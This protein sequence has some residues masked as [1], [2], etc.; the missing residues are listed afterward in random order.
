MA[1]RRKGPRMVE[2]ILRLHKI[3]LGNKAIARTL[4]ISKNTVKKYLSSVDKM[5]PA[6]GSEKVSAP[7]APSWSVELNWKDILKESEKGV[8]LSSLWEENVCSQIQSSKLSGVPYVSFWREFRRRYPK[9]NLDFHKT[10][11]PAERCE[12][13]FKGD[14]AGL[15]F[16]ERTTG[17]FIE[18]RFFGSILCYSQRFYAQ[19]FLAEKQ[20]DWLLGIGSGFE[21]FGGVTKLLTVDNPR[22][23]VR[24]ASWWDPDL[25]PE[26]FR[27]CEHFKTA[28]VPARPKRPKDKNLIEGA[29]GIF[30]RWAHIKIKNRTFFSLGELNKF[31]TELCNDFNQRVQRKYGAS[32][33][34][35]FIQNEK[36]LLL[37]L[38]KTR[39]EFAQWKKAKLH[40]DCHAQ[41]K[42]NYYSA[43]YELRGRELDVRITGSFI[44]IF[45]KLKRV[46]LH[47]V[48]PTQLYKGHYVTDKSH[49]PKAHQ[50]MLEATP[51]RI[52]EDSLL[53]GPE[54]RKIVDRLLNGSMHP[55]MYLRRCQGILRLSKRHGNQRLE[56]ASSFL[57][58]L[59]SQKPK[60]KDFEQ[61]LENKEFETQTNKLEPITR[62]PN[63]LLR[64]QKT[65][66]LH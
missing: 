7:Y 29:L 61:L 27:F 24:E 28:P 65:W 13:D 25:N 17:E 3:G 33:L 51:Q 16:V 40:P 43:P 53:V 47:K 62:N 58:S 38:P 8:S 56:K 2:E 57:N 5:E 60:L 31:L 18:C 4:K 19:A 39:Y 30:W 20:G 21:Y 6:E 32:R 48:V 66:R 46:A 12:V 64:G 26:F 59:Q 23:M 34:D 15:G 9:I 1:A 54:T 36:S 49:L 35:R 41:I 50:A 11:P 55:L 14:A 10:H 52:L 22:A 63:P 44:E 37:E 45:Y 42:N